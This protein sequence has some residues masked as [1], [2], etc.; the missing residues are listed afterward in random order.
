MQETY[1]RASSGFER[2]EGGKMELTAEDAHEILS[3]SIY[4]ALEMH[5]SASLDHAGGFAGEAETSLVL[6]AS[7][8]HSKFNGVSKRVWRK[9]CES[10][11]KT[12]EAS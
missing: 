10:F 1:N 9:Y 5:D 7:I 4:E 12:A 6:G 8:R 3:Q 2:T 11:E